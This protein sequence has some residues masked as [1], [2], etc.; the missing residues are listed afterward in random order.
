MKAKE[1]DPVTT[2]LENQKV[3]MDKLVQNANSV[4]DLYSIKEVPG[5]KV[6]EDFQKETQTYLKD[7]FKPEDSSK[8]VE[9]LPKN[10]A[11]AVELQSK[12]YKASVD[13]AMNFWK[14]WESEGLQ[15]KIETA[16]KLYQESAN[17]I[18]ETTNKNLESITQ[19]K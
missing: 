19:V 13:F 2:I 9:Q 16:N 8:F 18:I 7:V 1:K 3:L 12:F 10:L 11:K 15:K 17:A 14:D 5:G 4:L 6:M